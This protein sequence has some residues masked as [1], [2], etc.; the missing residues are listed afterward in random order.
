MLRWE[1]ALNKQ[2]DFWSQNER[3]HNA[4]VS[5]VFFGGGTPSLLANDILERVGAK[6]RSSFS[7]DASV[8]WTVECNPETISTDKLKTLQ[9]MG[10]NRLSIGVQSFQDEQLLRLERHAKRKDNLAALELVA[11]K[12]V[13]RWSFDL[14]FGLPTQSLEDW[15]K[16][17][18]TALSFSPQHLSAYQLT[19]GTE[20]SKN[21]Q[22]PG[23]EDLLFFYNLTEEILESAGLSKY[24]ISNFAKPGFQSQH[25]LAYWRTQPFLG[26]GPGAAGLFAGDEKNP[27]G[28]HQKN[29]DK[30]ELWCEAAGRVVSE[31][32]WLTPRIQKDHVYEMLM[33]GLRIRE[34][35]GVERFGSLQSQVQ[36]VF[37]QYVALGMMKIVDQAKKTY[38][39]TARGERILDS[40]LPNIY[41]QL[42]SELA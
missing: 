33:M 23:E 9:N 37:D 17:L 21:W 20:R 15:A 3:F 24:E 10:A 27:F 41:E 38:A 19:L 28:F 25:N 31:E 22:Q 18:E 42:S 16:E 35:I 7:V 11:S 8:E 2:I 1:Q 30:F 6:I 40:L 39:M 14:M 29:P 36:L 13:G 34:G 12:W 32:S 26:I 5:S 4:A